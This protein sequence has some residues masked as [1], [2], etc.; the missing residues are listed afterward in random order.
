MNPKTLAGLF[1]VAMLA[2]LTATGAFG[3]WAISPELNDGV[4]TV[5]V[6][7]APRSDVPSHTGLGLERRILEKCGTRPWQ[8]ITEDPIARAPGLEPT[9]FSAVDPETVPH[10]TY[11]YR[12]V[13]FDEEDGWVYG[14]NLCPRYDA[15]LC[16]PWNGAYLST[17]PSGLHHLGVGRFVQTGS[18]SGEIDLCNPDCQPVWGTQVRLFPSD[19]QQILDAGG[20]GVFFGRQD[21]PPCDYVLVPTVLGF[22]PVECTV[23]V[24]PSNWGALKA[25]W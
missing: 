12:V 7:V 15:E 1:L 9:E 5:H 18:Y 24:A 4:I 23:P 17:W 19:L 14:Y 16:A 8:R 6:R 10:V 13:A 20:E 25:R 22:W 11:Q 2:S 21:A 3:C